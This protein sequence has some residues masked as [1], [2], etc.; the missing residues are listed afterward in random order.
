MKLWTWFYN[1]FLK[2]THKQ[3]Q[4]E[5]RRANGLFWAA[6][7]MLL[8]GGLASLWCLASMQVPPESA[9]WELVLLARIALFRIPTGLVVAAL[10]LGTAIMAMQWLV[11]TP[12]GRF[13]MLWDDE[14]DRGSIELKAA[15]LRNTGLVFSA[16]VLGSFVFWALLVAGK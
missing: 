8:G 1:T 16:L 12:Q 5:R 9:A 10:A 4:A 3:T 13:S 14:K 2:P 7:L 15:K 6:G 11:R